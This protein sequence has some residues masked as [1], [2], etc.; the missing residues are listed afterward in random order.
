MPKDMKKASRVVGQCWGEHKANLYLLDQLRDLWPYPV[1]KKK[2]KGF[3]AAWPACERVLIEDAAAGAPLIV[4]LKDEVRGIIA[5]T[6]KGSKQARLES[7]SGTIEAGNVWLPH[8]SIASKKWYRFPM[9]ITTTRSTP[10][11]RHCGGINRNRG[12][13]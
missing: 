8:P 5:I 3:K 6:P 10:C 7:V 11:R 12:P 13:E 4:D 2:V 1:A 9:P